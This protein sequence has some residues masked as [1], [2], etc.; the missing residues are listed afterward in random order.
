MLSQ[1]KSALTLLACMLLSTVFVFQ[2]CGKKSSSVATDEDLELKIFTDTHQ[3]E[4]EG[5]LSTSGKKNVKNGTVCPA[6]YDPV[7]MKG[8]KKVEYCEKNLDFGNRSYQSCKYLHAGS[9][10]YALFE[11]YRISSSGCIEFSVINCAP[12]YAAC[13]NSYSCSCVESIDC[14]SG[15][16]DPNTKMCL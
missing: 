13:N 14:R 1:K 12:K 10:G 7:Y 3:Q 8:S 15:K 6:G 2:N 16:Y 11:H 5:E 4:V 9:D